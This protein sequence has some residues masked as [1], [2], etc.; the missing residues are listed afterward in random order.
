MKC[1][2]SK[3]YSWNAIRTQISNA[4]Q[5]QQAKDQP[6]QRFHID[7]QFNILY[8]T[9]EQKL[10]HAYVEE[11][12]SVLNQHFNQAANILF[13]SVQPTQ[14]FH[15]QQPFSANNVTQTI[16][17]KYNV[18]THKINVFVGPFR[19]EDNHVLGCTHAI[20][21]HLLFINY[22]V[23]GGPR[24]STHLIPQCTQGKTLVHEMGHALSL[25]H[26][27]DILFDIQEY[28]EI[29]QH[30][31]HVEQE[32]EQEYMRTKDNIMNC[33]NDQECIRFTKQ[34]IQQ[35][36]GYLLSDTHQLCL[37]A[38]KTTLYRMKSRTYDSTDQQVIAFIFIF[39]LIVLM[40]AVF[41][42]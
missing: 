16:I 31:K 19:S 24:L 35:M 7:I 5:I 28:Q 22:Q 13:S 41:S 42:T 17:Q 20:P 8:Q 3:T 33:G 10:D 36:R 32:E 30:P 18:N 29:F 15:I 23:F 21:S 1:Q 12:L 6:N 9:K 14:Y 25:Q 27:N 4:L 37:D 11:S 40:I 26:P 2:V 34:Q 39:L 38:N